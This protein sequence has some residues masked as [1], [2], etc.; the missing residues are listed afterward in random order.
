MTMIQKYTWR[1]MAPNPA[2]S[3]LWSDKPTKKEGRGGVGELARMRELEE[4]E[5]EK[6]PP[7]GDGQSVFQLVGCEFP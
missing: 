1:K 2:P 7:G 5:M 4:K 3:H 6:E